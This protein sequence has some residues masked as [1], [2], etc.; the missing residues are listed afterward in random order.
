MRAPYLYAM[1]FP[2][3]L[4]P[5]TL[6][7]RYKRFL[8]DVS[9]ES[10]DIVTAHCANPGSMLGLAEAGRKVWLSRSTN[11]KRKLKYSWELVEAEGPHGTEFVGINTAW[12]NVIAA[13]AIAGERIPELAGYGRMRREVNYGAGSRI[14]ILL[15]DAKRPP[16]YVEVKNV[17]LSRRPGVA[18]FPDSVTARGARHLRELA[19]LVRGKARAVMLYIVQRRADV[20]AFAGDIDSSY[21]AAFEQARSHGV[22]A[23][24]YRCDVSLDGIHVAGKI[25]IRDALLE[26]PKT[27]PAGMDCLAR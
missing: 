21:R 27:K 8:A 5:G 13:E 15:E 14:D 7:K 2:Q 6:I 1:K 12:P 3:P 24:C 10:G 18:E 22:E 11:P 23:L 19:E 25:P 26:T 16:C 9:L 4:I 17:H 20:F